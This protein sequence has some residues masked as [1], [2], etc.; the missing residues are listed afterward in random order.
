M[1]GFVTP[2]S[3]AAATASSSASASTAVSAA[4]TIIATS[5]LVWVVWLLRWLLVRV[6]ALSPLV[7]LPRCAAT[8]FAHSF[9]GVVGDLVG[10][11]PT[12][13]LGWG[14]MYCW[15]HSCLLL[16]WCEIRCVLRIVPHLRR[17][18]LA[19]HLELCES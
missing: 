13:L 12:V 15:G 18:C 6:G 7:L 16:V 2:A 9:V 3:S 4:P 1:R 11:L 5:T 14:H 8:S 17:R 19:S 10:V